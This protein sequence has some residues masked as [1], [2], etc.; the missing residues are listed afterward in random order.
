MPEFPIFHQ[1]G[2]AAEA[3]RSRGAIDIRAWGWL[4]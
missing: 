1:G 3:S 2:P 4:L